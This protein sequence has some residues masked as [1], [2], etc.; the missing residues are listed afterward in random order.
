VWTDPGNI[1]IAHRHMNVKIGTEAQHFLENKNI[2]GILV[3]VWV[4]AFVLDTSAY[5][6]S[7]AP[8]LFRYHLAPQILLRQVAILSGRHSL[9]HFPGS[10]S[11]GLSK[12][13]KSSTCPARSDSCQFF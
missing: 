1:E 13:G 12:S 6:H 2:N 5:T 9:A 10:P 3:A 8:L 7:C 4:A 11:A